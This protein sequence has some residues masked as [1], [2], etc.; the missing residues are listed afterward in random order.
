MAIVKRE[1]KNSPGG[2]EVERAPGGGPAWEEMACCAGKLS[3]SLEGIDWKSDDAGDEGASGRSLSLRRLHDAVSI[4]KGNLDSLFGKRS[5]AERINNVLFRISNAVNTTVNLEELYKTIHLALG[6]IIDVTNFFIALYDPGEDAL[7]F[8]YFVDETG[9]T[10]DPVLKKVRVKKS[11]ILTS[12]I[13][14]SGKQLYVKKDE[15]LKQLKR[16]GGKPYAAVAEAWLG[17]PLVVNGEVIGAMVVQSYTDP[18]LYDEKDA[19][20]LTA[21][22]EQ[23]AIAIDRK[24]AEEAQVVEQA[25]MERLFEGIR[26]GIAISGPDG[27]VMSVN[28]EFERLF[29]YSPGEAVEAALYDLIIPGSHM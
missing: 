26:E 15:R 5:R 6:D 23:I 21:V 11:P 10:L 2:D 27:V 17:T 24:R 9:V 12:R 28:P 7:S 19:E 29:G 20:I 3:A 16:D 22:A 1:N 4:M 18:D 14:R 13:I 25:H 8:P